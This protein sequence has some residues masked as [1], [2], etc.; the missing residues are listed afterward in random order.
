MLVYIVLLRIVYAHER[1]DRFNYML[2]VPDQIAINVRHRQPI[3][4]PP[5]ETSEV[6]DFPMGSAH[7]S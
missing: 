6:D 4:Q 7:G 2:R 3:G 5:Q 1:L